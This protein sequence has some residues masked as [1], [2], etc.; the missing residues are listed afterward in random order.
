[1][2]NAMKLQVLSNEDNTNRRSTD[3]AFDVLVTKAIKGDTAALSELCNQISKQALF[4]AS[5][6]TQNEKDAE[7][8]AQEAIIRVCQN[9]KEV[10]NPKAFRKW[11]GRIVV[12]EVRHMMNERNKYGNV[13]SIS[14]ELDLLTEENDDYLPSAYVESSE[15]RKE[16]IKAIHTLSARQREVIMLHYF[17]GLSITETAESMGLA[18][19]NVCLYLDN[20]H[21]KIKAELGKKKYGFGKVVSVSSFLPIGAVLSQTLGLES[22][23]FTPANPYWIVDTLMK[24]NDAI[25]ALMAGTTA[26]SVAAVAGGGVVLAGTGGTAAVAEITAVSGGAA[27]GAGAGTTIAGGAAAGKVLAS[28]ATA[29]G[30]TKLAAVAGGV[31]LTAAVKS[32]IAVCAA[33]ATTAAI[34]V[35]TLNMNRTEPEPLPHTNATAEI[36]FTGANEETPYIDPEGVYTISD[37]IYGAL[38]VDHWDIIET[39]SRDII[40]TGNS[41]N[42]GE[43][44]SE[45][46]ENGAS[47]EYIL[48]FHL[49]DALGVIHIVGHGFYLTENK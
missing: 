24:C 42:A 10:R 44:I 22:A 2:A 33:F 28:G 17:D 13:I 46:R 35:G 20:A 15:S 47:G 11:L 34:T 27:A 14:D 38:E 40:Q 25:L 12:N 3:T 21:K 6:I 49:T 1:M 23:L 19:S 41:E 37:S 45:L 5:L 18:K 39:E 26:A 36:I 9:I 43:T 32:G 30:G 48:E 29:A 8:A 7:N 31:K 16:V 4:Q